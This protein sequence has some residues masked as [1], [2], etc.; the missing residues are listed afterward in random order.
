MGVA[1][2]AAPGQGGLADEVTPG[3]AV[4]ARVCATNSTTLLELR[5]RVL[6]QL[7]VHGLAPGGELAQSRQ[8]RRGERGAPAERAKTTAASGERQCAFPLRP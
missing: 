5:E 3:D 4:V 7:H 6:D 2:A 8:G 1:K